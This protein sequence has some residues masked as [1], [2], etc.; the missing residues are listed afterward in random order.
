[1]IIRTCRSTVGGLPITTNSQKMAP[2]GAF[3]SN[4]RCRWFAKR[5]LVSCELDLSRSVF[6]MADSNPRAEIAGKNTHNKVM[7]ILQS[8]KSGGRIMDIPSG[9]GVFAHRLAAAGYSAVAADVVQ[10]NELDG[11][12]FHR[13]DMNEPLPLA[14]NSLDGLTCIEGIEHLERPFD[15]IRECA[16]VLA[17]DGLLILTTPNIS[18]I[19]SRW[20]Y[21]LTGFH[22]KCKYMLDETSPNPLHHINMLSFPALRYMLHVHGFQITH[23]DT[24]RIKAI[25][26]IYLPVALVQYLVTRVGIWRAKPDDI[27]RELSIVVLRQMLSLPAL[28]GES[29]VIVARK[30]SD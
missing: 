8:A 13:A 20:R 16:R 4:D 21:F 28:L 17:A 24:N 3:F 26:W 11:L 22:N 14:D 9:H 1:M 25:N 6:A 23:I 5:F 15:F 10:R 12:E 2:F 19:R 30:R 18:A 7:E 27:D 29:M